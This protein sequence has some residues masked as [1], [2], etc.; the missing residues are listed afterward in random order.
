MVVARAA[1][2][3]CCPGCARVAVGCPGGDEEPSN[4]LSMAPRPLGFW[5]SSFGPGAWTCL[6]K[7]MAVWEAT[8]QMRA[9]DP[10]HLRNGIGRIP[11][12][13]AGGIAQ[14]QAVTVWHLPGL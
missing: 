14:T 8:Q 1:S 4:A 2:V 6:Q 10:G 9:G 11:L 12:G 13:G 3:L 7:H 5:N